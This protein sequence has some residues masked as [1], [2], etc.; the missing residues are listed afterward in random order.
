M[1]EPSEKFLS[2]AEAA[3]FLGVK[4]ATLYAYASRGLIKSVPSENARERCYR[5]SDL[6]KL[7]QSSRGFKS[8]KDSEDP[9]WTGPVIKSAI[10]DITSE[11]HYYRGRNALELA[12]SDVPFEEVAE[13]IW[14]TE[15]GSGSN[16]KR[17]KPLPIPKTVRALAG[18]EVDYLDLLKLILASIEMEDSI[19]RTLLSDDVFEFARRLI[20]S[21]AAAAGL[22]A[23]T[24]AY[25]VEGDFPIAQTLLSSL[26]AKKSNERSRLINRALVLCA[27]H[28]LNASALAARIAASCD[29]SLYSCLLT[30]VGTFSGTRHGSASRRT[31]DTITNS[32]KF[33]TARAWLKD[34]LRQYPKIPGFGTE[35]YAKGDPRAKL[36][37]ETAQQVSS[38]N[39]HLKRLIELVDCVREQLGLEPNLDVGLAAITYALGLSPGAGSI[40]FAVSRTSGW[41]AHAVEQKMYGGVIRPRARYIGKVAGA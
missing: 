11:G 21:M 12:Q 3:E 30:A 35:L 32:M 13:L 39:N 37:I 27:D 10:T 2:G 18:P 26:V 33:K 1:Q 17:V 29:A 7:R 31:E 36:L 23:N 22:S 14:D 4:S 20:V 5:L 40:I 24:Y 41:I 15:P 34:Y 28:E 8:A 25:S 38:K 6:I 16:W 19:S 9:V